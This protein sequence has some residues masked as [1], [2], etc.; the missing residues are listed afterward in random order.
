M[1]IYNG[2]HFLTNEYV[3]I[4]TPISVTVMFSLFSVYMGVEVFI[5]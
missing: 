5:I 4:L 1:N 2:I 3:L